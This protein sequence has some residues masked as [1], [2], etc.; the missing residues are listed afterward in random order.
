MNMTFIDY[1]FYITGA[2]VLVGTFSFILMFFI[3]GFILG[4]CNSISMHRWTYE[5]AKKHDQLSTLKWV[6]LP[7][8]ILKESV[9]LFWYRNTGATVYSKNIGGTW[10][11][12]GDWDVE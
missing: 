6:K 2:I 8:S 10:R 11:G 4:L 7:W 9:E 3:V 5:V 1:A 12:I